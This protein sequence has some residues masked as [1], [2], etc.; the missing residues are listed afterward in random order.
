MS[1][2]S[3]V[4][5]TLGGSTT[6]PAGFTS[7]PYGNALSDLATAMAFTPDGRLLVAQKSGAVRVI[8]TGTLLG[9]VFATFPV[10]GD[11]ERGLIGI[12]VHPQF[13]SNGWVYVHYTTVV[14]GTVRGRI[15]RVT[16]SGDVAVAGSEVVIADLS[17]D[18][19][20]FH[21]GG[22]IH[23]GPDGRLYVA[24][25]DD[26]TTSNSQSMSTLHGKILR[27]NDD[28]SIPSSNP[29]YSTAAGQNRAIWALGLRNPFTFAFQP[30]TGRM[31]INDVGQDAWEEINEGVAGRN[32]GWP[33]TEGPT[34]DS[35]YTAPYFAY[36]H[37][38]GMLTGFS[39]TGGAFYNPAVQQ[40]P[41]EY[42][43]NYFFADYVSRWISRLDTAQGADVYA[44]ARMPSGITDLRVGADGAVYV[45]LAT[46]FSSAQVYRITYTP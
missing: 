18:I 11:G 12:A 10:N 3:S 46:S 6:V 4:N 9:P 20:I 14:D 21:N 40:F 24:T 42:A 41:A 32:F 44:F 19:S 25:G 43:G 37:H 36:H 2:W 28:G 38:T 5:V 30:G 39:I 13:S 26:A 29:F 31:F 33:H 45:L 1:Q 27:F 16:A 17:P 8:R 15:S 22:A 35:R 7:A 34:S 23:F